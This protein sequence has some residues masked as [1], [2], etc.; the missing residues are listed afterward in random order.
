M[1]HHPEKDS[2]ITGKIK[3]I[4]DLLNYA[5]RNELKD[6][7]G[8]DTSNLAA[9]KGFIALKGEVDKLGINKFL[10]V[11]SGLNSLENK[12][13]DAITLIHINQYNIYKQSLEKKWEMLIKDYLT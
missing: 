3:V 10:N 4:L 6:A 1:N 8:V 9:K 2:H 13:S 5:T 7:T 12:I 11:S